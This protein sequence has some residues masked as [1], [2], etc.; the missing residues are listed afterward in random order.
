M[1]FNGLRRVSSGMRENLS[2]GDSRHY[3]DQECDVGA[4][5]RGY[6]VPGWLY[7]CET[8]SRKLIATEL[9]HMSSSGILSDLSS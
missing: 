7:I 9:V 8:A 6:K 1:L 3:Q 4:F 2:V 5:W